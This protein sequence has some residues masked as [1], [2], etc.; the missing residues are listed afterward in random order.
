MTKFNQKISEYVG[1]GHPD[2]VADLI[3]KI[4]NDYAMFSATEVIIN[5]KGCYISG[6]TKISN[7]KEHKKAILK[8]LK[9]IQVDYK[10]NKKIPLKIN[11]CK[12]D[13][14]LSKR[15]IKNMAGDQE[16]V[17]YT[18]LT[19]KDIHFH[20]KEWDNFINENFSHTMD[21]KI[22]VNLENKTANISYSTLHWASETITLYLTD[23]IK[24]LDK[25][26]KIHYCPFSGGSVF[27][28]TGVTGRKLIVESEGCGNP[29]GGGAI[30]GKCNTKTAPAG[31]NLL[32]KKNKKIVVYFPGDDLNKPN[33]IK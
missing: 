6:E 3:A 10:K 26:I 23:Q 1:K 2:R 32:I 14:M 33:Y 13:K 20:L 30:Y 9:E 19:K 4:T 28:D 27:S 17:Y 18:K 24:K 22:L 15:R 11:F 12:Q 29:H 8:V 5:E 16:I 7:K 25:D 31:K 21:Y